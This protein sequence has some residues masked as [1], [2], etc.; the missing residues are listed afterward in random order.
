MDDNAA[1]ELFREFL[2]IPTLS[3]TGVETGSYRRAADWL[4][5]KLSELLVGA[6]VGELEV[7]KGKPI[8]HATLPG[9]DPSLPLVLLNSHYDVV[10]ADEQHWDTDPFAAELT[11]DGKIFGR[12]TQDMK[13]VCIQYIVALQRL[14]V[15]ARKATGA[16]DDAPA[17]RRTIVLTFVP[18]EEIGGRDGMGALLGSDFFKNLG[19]IG[20]ALD[21]G[22]ANPGEKY[23]VFYGERSPWWIIVE[24]EGPTGHGSRFIENPATHRLLRVAQKGIE[25]RAQQEKALGL[26][27]VRALLFMHCDCSVRSA[28][29][30]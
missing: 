13:S 17:F 30:I 22:L 29:M 9:S 7:K 10:P 12:G 26:V 11:E 3:T 15:Q 21:E 5:E 1:V 16:E 25:F 6:E 27:E 23:T 14:L 28:M 24:A 8:V 4:K 18:D 2:R 19:E 20:L